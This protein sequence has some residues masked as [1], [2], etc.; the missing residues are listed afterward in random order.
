MYYANCIPIDCLQFFITFLM[1]KPN[2]L[3]LIFYYNQETTLN[4]STRLEIRLEEPSL[5]SVVVIVLD[6]AILDLR[7]KIARSSHWNTDV[8]RFKF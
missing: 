6:F 5:V 4:F 1:I 7:L 3:I 2:Y 8:K